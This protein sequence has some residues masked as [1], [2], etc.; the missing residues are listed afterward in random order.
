[1]AKVLGAGRCIAI[2]ER[3][4]PSAMGTSAEKGR[5]RAVTNT[6]DLWGWGSRPGRE[7]PK[8]TK[9]AEE[10]V[11]TVTT[12]LRETF[13]VAISEVSTGGVGQHTTIAPNVINHTLK[14]TFP[15]PKTMP[16][17]TLPI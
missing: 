5:L 16:P 4:F 9:Q 1:M 17:S 3:G 8:A 13:R 6:C 7:S 14:N 12:V 2:S 15:F 11:K 10:I